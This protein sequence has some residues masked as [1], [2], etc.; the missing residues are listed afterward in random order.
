MSTT[1]REW[2]DGLDGV[3]AGARQNLHHWLR[4]LFLSTWW[5]VSFREVLN[6]KSESET[7]NFSLFA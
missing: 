3:V 2:R 1:A 5:S 6:V 4:P 7:N